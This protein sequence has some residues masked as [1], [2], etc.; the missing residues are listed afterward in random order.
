MSYNFGLTTDLG[1][2]DPNNVS[3]LGANAI[4]R[5]VVYAHLCTGVTV[6]SGQTTLVRTATAV[7]L[8]AA[9]TYCSNNNKIFQINEGVYEIYSSTGLIVPYSSNPFTWQGS[10]GARIIQF[11]ATTPGAPVLTIG[12]PAGVNQTYSVTINGLDVEYGVAQTGFASSVNL[13][14]SANTASNISNVSVGAGSNTFPAYNCATFIGANFSNVFTNWKVNGAQVN[15]LNLLG[16]GTGNI[17]DDF[18]LNLS[19]NTNAIT[20]NY[21][22]LAAGSQEQDF[23]QINCEHGSCAQVINLNGTGGI[24]FSHLHL[25]GIILTGFNPSFIGINGNNVI[26]S[27]MTFVDN[28]LN[29]TNLSGTPSVINDYAPGKNVS[30]I[31]NF[32]WICNNTAEINTPFNLFSPGGLPTNYTSNCTIEGFI[33]SD[34]G[35]GNMAAH[36]QLDPHMPIS[37]SAFLAPQAFSRYDY[38]IAGSKVSKAVIPVT[39]TYTHYGQHEDANLF[40]PA[41]ITSFTLTLAD[42]MGATGTQ[43]PR[44]GNTVHIQR[45]SGT[46]SGTLTIKDGAGTTLTTNT[47][48]AVDLYYQFTGTLWATFTPVT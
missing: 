35:G 4:I 10:S 37:A 7:A 12:D 23:R 30:K 8:Q 22:Y 5:G 14:V 48:S 36:L 43:L 47:T 27:Q 45:S 38:G 13:I 31:S 2:D 21:I 16:L 17:F 28:V 20:G 42:T 33:Q 39:T 19:V 11:Y 24:N 25:E 34:V 1:L 41:S 18:Y 46:A 3:G 9:I 32:N 6:G 44:T 15:M 29:T 40:V 26:I